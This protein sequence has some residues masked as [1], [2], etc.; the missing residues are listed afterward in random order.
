MDADLQAVLLA[1]EKAPA[2]VK[3]H[4]TAVMKLLVSMSKRLEKLENDKS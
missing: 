4:L 1:Y 3:P 2:L